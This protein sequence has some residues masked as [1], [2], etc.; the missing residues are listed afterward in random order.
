[1]PLLDDR[2]RLFGKV[3]LIDLAVVAVLVGLMPVA[4]ASWKLFQTPLAVIDTVTPSVLQ[5]NVAKQQIQLTGKNLRPFLRTY[6]QVPQGSAA[7][8]FLFASPDHAVVELPAL[9][10]GS[11]DLVL[12]DE[13]REIGRLPKILNVAAVPAPTV[14]SVSPSTLEYMPLPQHLTLKGKGFVPGLKATVGGI[15]ASYQLTSPEVVELTTPALPTGTFDIVLSDGAQEL[16]RVP[17]AVTVPK[18]VLVSISPRIVD[19]SKDPQ[20]VEFRGKH[21]LPTLR[22][23][24]G[25]REV[26]TTFVSLEQ[27]EFLLPAFPA[28]VFDITVFDPAGNVELARF[29]NA[30]TVQAPQ[31]VD[32]TMTARFIVRPEVLAAVKP[33]SGVAPAGGQPVVESYQVKGELAGTSMN[34]LKEGKQQIITASVRLMATRRSEGLFYDGQALRAGGPI[35][36]RT[37]G[38]QLTGEILGIDTAARK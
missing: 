7:T 35:V 5:P 14:K 3:N 4:Y 25:W 19:V 17:A 22:V 32:V 33:A 24:V 23:F 34:E 27:G 16:V 28:G 29:K 11:F 9:T 8:T 37:P 30:L 20:R 38:Y 13:T 26:G 2:G 31:L 10:P 15:V 12:Y 1:M 18:P 6:V 21:F 36:L